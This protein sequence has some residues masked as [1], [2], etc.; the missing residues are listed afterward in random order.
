MEEKKKEIKKEINEKEVQKEQKEKKEEKKVNK[1]EEYKNENKELKEKIKE[2][3]E[4]LKE[5]ENYARLIK[6]QFENFKKDVIKEKEQLVVSTTGRIVE[7][8]IPVIDDFK[9][10]FLNAEE[11]VKNTNFYKGIELIYKNLFKTLENLG[12][13]ELAVGEK[14]DPFEQEAVERIEDEQKEEYTIVEIVEDG[15]KFKDRVI[16]PAKVKVT[17]KPRR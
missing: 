10:A 1:I 4:Q 11:E 12:L 3:E 9:R 5:F 6:S 2:L 8:F 17:V 16:K 15:Y 14:F 13:S 7:R